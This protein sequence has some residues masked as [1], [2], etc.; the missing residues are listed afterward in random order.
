[1]PAFVASSL[2]L[3]VCVAERVCCVRL[4]RDEDANGP[5]I[6]FGS[7]PASA[8]LPPSFDGESVTSG[9]TVLVASVCRVV[10]AGGRV[11]G[12]RRRLHG[13]DSLSLAPSSCPQ[14]A[15]RETHDDGPGPPHVEV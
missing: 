12:L 15:E 2:T 6:V 11:A 5:V 13:G 9:C 10:T 1:M 7:T 8:S 3:R 14:R 4:R